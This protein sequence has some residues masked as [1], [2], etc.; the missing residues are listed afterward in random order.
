MA[1]QAYC[2][3]NPVLFEVNVMVTR[4]EAMI[5]IMCASTSCDHLFTLSVDLYVL[6][7]QLTSKREKE[8]LKYSV[9][10]ITVL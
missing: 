3:W 8:R 9:Q 7:H 10:R 4:H 2:V 5:C 6:C 1:D